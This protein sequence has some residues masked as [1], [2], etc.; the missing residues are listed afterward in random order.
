MDFQPQVEEQELMVFEEESPKEEK[1]GPIGSAITSMILGIL[2]I[3][4]GTIPGIV[5]ACIA[6]AKAKRFLEQYPE[7][8]YK[9]FA[10]V[11]RITGNVGLPLSIVS[12]VLTVLSVIAYILSYVL[13]ELS[14]AFGSG[15]ADSIISELF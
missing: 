14:F 9:G 3:E 11:G 10:K 7:S 13:T 15:I 1:N 6:R 8:S 2:S 4:L 12:T 5:L